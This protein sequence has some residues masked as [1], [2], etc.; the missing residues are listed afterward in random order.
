[1]KRRTFLKN[2]LLVSSSVF[3][4]PSAVR[5][6]DLGKDSRTHDKIS[7]LAVSL[8]EQWCQGLYANQTIDPGNTVTD[9]G[10]YSPGDQAYLGRCADALYPFLWMAR[11]TNDEKYI[12]AAKKVYAWEQNNCWNEEFGC[13]YNDPGRPDGW[14]SISVFAAITKMEAIEHYPDLL[15]EETIS[16]WKSRLQL[17]AE[18]IYK[19]FHVEYANIKC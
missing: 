11:H 14:K 18:Y 5:C 4:R 2:S 19:T 6:L 12:V 9:G 17:V 1:M 13:W 3:L 15:G 7:E 16:K 10:I 8:L